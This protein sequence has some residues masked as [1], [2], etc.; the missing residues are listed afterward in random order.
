MASPMS[1]QKALRL[2]YAYAHKD[3]R[4]R[5]KLEITL[6]LL[7]QQALIQDWHDQKIGA[8]QEWQGEIHKQLE[9]ADIIL[10]LISSDFLA[11]DYCYSKEMQ[12][13]LERHREGTARVVPIIVRTVNWQTSELAKLRAL[14][15]DGK[16]VDRWTNKDAA[17]ANIED[18]IRGII[19]EFQ[20]HP[21]LERMV[22]PATNGEWNPLFSR[23]YTLLRVNS[24]QDAIRSF[25]PFNT[26]VLIG[27]DER[28]DIRLADDDKKASRFHCQIFW[29]SEGVDVLDLH[30]KNGTFVN[31]KRV[32]QARLQIGDNLRCGRTLFRLEDY[33]ATESE[34]NEDE[35]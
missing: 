9:T 23:R 17:W 5:D 21:R 26:Q 29:S 24:T 13:A 6:G 33:N 34:K 7:R 25:L 15:K 11:S 27:R 30:S 18:G 31:D 19:Q 12:R 1:D 16:P 35:M 32:S 14:P 2:F 28:A 3:E 8:G 10:L 22:Q 20:H 4:L